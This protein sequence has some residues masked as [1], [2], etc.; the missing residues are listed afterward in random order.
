[1]PPWPAPLSG[2]LEQGM[3]ASELLRGNPLGDPAE[4]PLWVYLPP[5]YPGQQERYPSVY[6]LHGY[7]GSVASWGN[8]PTK[9]A[10]PHG[11]SAVPKPSHHAAM[12]ARSRIPTKPSRA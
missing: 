3:F 5:G 8:R 4:R 1:M 6:L 2:R 9:S 10:S 11:A 7:G 12:A